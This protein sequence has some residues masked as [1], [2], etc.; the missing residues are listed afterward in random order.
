M[1]ML[2]KVTI[3]APKSSKNDHKCS[4]HRESLLVVNIM[5]V[6][7]SFIAETIDRTIPDITRVPKAVRTDNATQITIGHTLLQKLS[8]V[9][10]LAH[11]HKKMFCLPM[12]TPLPPSPN[13]NDPSMTEHSVFSVVAEIAIQGPPRGRPGH[14]FFVSHVFWSCRLQLRTPNKKRKKATRRDGLYEAEQKSSESWQPAAPR[15]TD[16]GD[17]TPTLPSHY[18]LLIDELPCTHISATR[19]RYGGAQRSHTLVMWT[20]CSSPCIMHGSLQ[21]DPRLFL[22]GMKHPHKSWCDNFTNFL[23]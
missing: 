10:T 1:S 16:G 18:L 8:G 3:S 11:C 9:Q 19:S 20:S 6:V 12:H 13:N 7:R 5:I 4:N 17:T 14:I 2:P 15:H 23:K 21:P 22:L